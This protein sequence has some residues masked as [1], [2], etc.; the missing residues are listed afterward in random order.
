MASRIPVI[1]PE[2]SMVFKNNYRTFFEKYPTLW[3]RFPVN[4]DFLTKEGQ[5]SMQEFAKTL[6]AR[7]Q[8]N[9]TDE[10]FYNERLK[11]LRVKDLGRLLGD[12]DNLK[13]V[14]GQFKNAEEK[15]GRDER[16]A[17]LRGRM[18][19]GSKEEEPTE[20]LR[21]YRRHLHLK[22]KRKTRLGE[23]EERKIRLPP[24][25]GEREER[26]VEEEPIELLT[27]S[28]T[29]GSFTS[30]KIEE[31]KF[32]FTSP[33]LGREKKSE[34]KEEGLVDW[35]RKH[36]PKTLKKLF[37]SEEPTGAKEI[38]EFKSRITKD[39]ELMK[40][41]NNIKGSGAFNKRKKEIND[42]IYNKMRGGENIISYNALRR[43]Y[44]YT[45]GKY[46]DVINNIAS[47]ENLRKYT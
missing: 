10:E 7:Q 41:L 11:N 38:G 27:Y 26:E 12:E 35:V 36:T 15:L 37:T 33:K 5:I 18:R 34:K 16:R 17:E 30:P 44:N 19:E 29:K 2:P 40:K 8:A 4:L 46:E 32:P 25:L 43:S 28:S 42:Y 3:A 31:R 45:N 1:N 9:L 21:K 22:S 39:K 23:R 6:E 14:I 47:K 13:Y 20:Q 24:R